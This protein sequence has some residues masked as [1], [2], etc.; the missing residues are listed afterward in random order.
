V[1]VVPMNLGERM[2]TSYELGEAVAER[3]VEAVA[4][5]GSRT[6]VVVRIGRPMPDTLPGG[7][8][9]CPR[10]IVG[11]GEESVAASFGVDSLQALLLA[12]YALRLDLAERA[13]AAS[14]RLDWLGQP[15]LGLRVDPNPHLLSP[16]G[17]RGSD[18]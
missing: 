6:S 12:V 9:Y 5:D 7:D 17:G 2:A 10:Q 4:E 8:W 3:R 1:S 18:A 11:L 13:E 14:V 16:P 15:D